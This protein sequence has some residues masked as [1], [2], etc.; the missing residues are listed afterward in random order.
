M[1]DAGVT[2]L[3]ERSAANSYQMLLG[4]EPDGDVIGRVAE[5]FGA[6]LRS[7][8]N[9]DPPL[10]A[11]AF[12]RNSGRDLLTLRHESSDGREF[13]ARLTEASPL[14]QWR[15][16]LTVGVPASGTPWIA[17]QVS[18]SEGRWT[19]VPALA[20]FLLEALTT[21]DGSTTLSSGARVV[22]AAD[23]DEVLEEICDPDRQGLLL[24]AGSGHEGGDFSLYVKQVERWTRQVRGLAQVVVLTPDATDE[25]WRL[26]GPSHGIRSWTLRTFYPDADPAVPADG[27]RHKFLTTERLANESEDGVRKLLGR[28][29][30][31]HAAIRTLPR[32]FVRADR[33][34]RRVEDQ[35]LVESLAVLLPEP[36][37][38][39][40]VLDVES[41]TPTIVLPDTVEELLTEAESTPAVQQS[42]APSA[43]TTPI[44]QPPQPQ[45]NAEPGP[46][47]VPHE[48]TEYLA[49]L[50]M[51]KDTLGVPEVTPESLTQVVAQLRNAQSVARA[52]EHVRTQLVEREEL[53]A[54]AQD[55][56]SHYQER[57]DDVQLDER[58]A[59]QQA[60][61]LADENRW[62]KARLAQANDFEAAYGVVPDDAYT[63]YPEN[64]DDLQR[65]LPELADVGV[66]FTGSTRDMLAVDD[67]DVVGT[68]VATA[69]DAFLVLADYVRAR[70]AG[71]FEGSIK[72]YLEDTPQGYRQMPPKKFGEKETGK[73]MATW[74]DQR[75][76]PVPQDVDS[77]GS[78]VME[79]HFKLAKVGMASP[80]MHILD[81]WSTH[82][83]V[84]VGYIGP[85]LRNTQTN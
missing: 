23:V 63:K 32:S 80:R 54:E 34:L 38:T 68:A 84:Y 16:Q 75:M 44:L 59:A 6:W 15:T 67:V 26:L 10:D 40:E 77:S 76:F 37:G 72:Q 39:D 71:A 22:H 24:V 20:G 28:T 42:I 78:R 85:H 58:I 41:G 36:H 13:R 73:T 8:K 33:A 21:K 50:K 46:A 5:Q 14:G 51:V 65:R 4:V 31:R 52:V 60:S 1:A 55:R 70:N 3:D 66:I 7:R 56:A 29:A 81:C 9:W 45:S 12:Q 48:P 79:A 74:G 27:L 53:L 2:F 19:Q 69:W 25:A 35:M 47:V 11:D 18:N 43:E 17:L 49:L 62:L 83:T 61:Q 30:R 82:K 64:F 57:Y